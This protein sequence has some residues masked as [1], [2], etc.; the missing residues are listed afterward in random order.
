MQ[1]RYYLDVKNSLNREKKSLYENALNY[2]LRVDR[3]FAALN[4]A[5]CDESM[6]ILPPI[7]CSVSSS[8]FQLPPS[9]DKE[10]FVS[11]C[12][13]YNCITYKSL[14]YILNQISIAGGFNFPC[15]ESIQETYLPDRNNIY[16]LQT[17]IKSLVTVASVS[18]WVEDDKKDNQSAEE[19][20]RI[21]NIP[22]ICG[23]VF[24][25]GSIDDK[26]LSDVFVSTK[27]PRYYS[28]YMNDQL[29]CMVYPGTLFAPISPKVK[30]PKKV[31]PQTTRKISEENNRLSNTVEKPGEC[32]ILSYSEDKEKRKSLSG[33]SVHEIPNSLIICFDVP[34]KDG[35]S[36]AR[37]ISIL[38]KISEHKIYKKDNLDNDEQIQNFVQ[39]VIQ[40]SMNDLNAT[41]RNADTINQMI[42]EYLR[43]CANNY[44]ALDSFWETYSLENDHIW[45]L[46]FSLLYYYSADLSVWMKTAVDAQEQSMDLEPRKWCVK[47][48]GFL[49]NRE[50]GYSS[51][52]K[53][54]SKVLSDLFIGGKQDHIQAN[55]ASLLAV[56][57]AL[58]GKC[59]C[60][61]KKGEALGELKKVART[62]KRRINECEH[63]CYFGYDELDGAVTMRFRGFKECSELPLISEKEEV[64]ENHLI[65]DYVNSI[66]G[67]VKKPDIH[68]LPPLMEAFRK[69]A[70]ELYSRFIDDDR[71]MNATGNPDVY[72]SYH[73]LLQSIKDNGLL[74]LPEFWE[75]FGQINREHIR[76]FIQDKLPDGLSDLHRLKFSLDDFD[77]LKEYINRQEVQLVHSN[78]DGGDSENKEMGNATDAWTASH[79]AEKTFPLIP[80]LRA[81]IPLENLIYSV[82]RDYFRRK[83][84]K[85]KQNMEE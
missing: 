78:G 70:P 9:I 61:L 41:S 49:E 18:H 50:K 10:S 68:Y 52:I 80:Q 11:H 4:K 24:R 17:N 8:L 39:R 2:R 26:L 57:M 35:Q 27:S 47:M 84:D 28:E 74:E 6:D 25:C 12:D 43:S 67:D 32:Y 21:K 58:L 53:V 82:S 31:M 59:K 69:F 40:Y 60:S 64:L 37:N 73:L 16:N 29:C 5:L 13:K 71:S 19:I 63:D 55:T 81:H 62:I 7:P 75:L 14:L 15:N 77:T 51:N 56:G 36:I 76:V 34:E 20:I 1:T 22:W 72:V 33:Y 30:Q 46:F 65:D 23:L 48:L 66:N 42:A 44:D 54:V 79:S 85:G 38:K 3:Y 45:V 83:R